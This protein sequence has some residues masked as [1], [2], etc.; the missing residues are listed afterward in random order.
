MDPHYGGLCC[1]GPAGL[2]MTKGRYSLAWDSVWLAPAK[3]NLFLHVVGRRSDG[4]HLL[5]TVFRF[6]D[7]HDTLRFA[8]RDDG[9]VVQ[10][11]P[12]S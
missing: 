8:P 1:H 10:A 6:L 9:K 12:Q 3:I 5:Q 7:I 4:Y 11:S 2:A